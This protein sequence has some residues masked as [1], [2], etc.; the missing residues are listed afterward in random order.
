MGAIIGGLYAV[1]YSGEQ[2]EKIILE[3]DFIALLRDKLPRTTTPFFEKEY[4]EKA[5]IS[6]PILK[7]K[8]GLPKGVSKGQNMLSFLIELFSETATVSDFSKTPNSIFFDCNR[9]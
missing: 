4:G 8:V 5:I 2:I 6:L 3:T 7:G 1:G 9:C